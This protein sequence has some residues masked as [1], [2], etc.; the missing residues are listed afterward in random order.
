MTLSYDGHDLE[1]LFICGEPELSILNFQPEL[2]DVAS[3]NGALL[4][5]SKIGTST[6]AFTIVAT[7]TASERRDKFSTLGGWLMV[8]VPKKLILPDTPDRYYAA[9]PQGALD[10]QRGFDGEYAVLT[11]TLTD[12]IAYSTTVNTVTS[13]NGSAT[14]TVNGTAPAY[15]TVAHASNYVTVSDTEDYKWG[16]GLSGHND[17]L[18]SRRAVT[19]SSGNVQL[20]IDVEKRTFKLAGV[21]SVVSLDSSWF[22]LEPGTNTITR[23]YGSREFKVKWRDRWY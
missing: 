2:N 9:V 4:L 17:K 20:E 11:F 23:L 21:T 18:I 10:L 22:M 14:V 3:R 5:G 16:I 15:F 19:G 8:D 1:S 6:V 13:I 7:G 12:P